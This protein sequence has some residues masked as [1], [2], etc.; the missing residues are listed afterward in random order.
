MGFP[1]VL[2]NYYSLKTPI[3]FYIL[4]NGGNYRICLVYDKGN[5][6][7]FKQKEYLHKK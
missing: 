4:S 3:G 7:Y 1:N 6:K 5:R 2:Q